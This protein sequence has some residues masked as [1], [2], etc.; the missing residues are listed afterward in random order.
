MRQPVKEW[1]EEQ[2]SGQKKV[3]RRFTCLNAVICTHDALPTGGWE[4]HTEVQADKGTF[5]SDINE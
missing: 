1:S 4:K 3:D 2:E 5:F